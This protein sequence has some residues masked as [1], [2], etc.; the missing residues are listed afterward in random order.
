MLTQRDIEQR[1]RLHPLTQAGRLSVR[2]TGKLGG[3]RGWRFNILAK[4]ASVFDARVEFIES[5]R[6]AAA[7]LRELKEE[8]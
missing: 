8:S 2:T 1:A 7:R 3:S 5:N 6:A 4:G